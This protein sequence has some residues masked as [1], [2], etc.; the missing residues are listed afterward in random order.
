M[1]DKMSGSSLPKASLLSAFA[2][3]IVL[4]LVHQ[5]LFFGHGLGVSMPIFVIVFYVYMYS[6]NRDRCQPLSWIGRLL[7]VVIMMLALTYVLFDNPI[8]YVLNALAIAA[9][10]SV[11]MVLLFGEKSHGWSE[12]GIIGQALS[13]W[14]YQNFRHIVTPFR[15][16]KTAAFRN[17]KDER[18]RVLGKVII[19]LLIALPLL[20]IIISLLASADGMFEKLLSG[21]PAWIGT[22]TFGSGLPRLIWTCFFTF[23]FFCY[24]WGFVQPAPRNTEREA[25]P[26][27]AVPYHEPV[28]IKF[29]PVITATVLIVMNLVYVVFVVLQFGYLFGAW[30]G[31]LPEGT[32]YAEYAR[33]GFG[34]LVMVTGINFVLM[35]SVLKWTE[36][37]S[38]IVQTLNS[39][40]LYI[41]VG[42]SGVMLYSGYTRLVMYEEAYGYTYIRYL[43]HAFMIFLGLLLLVAAVRIHVRQLP[44]A[45]YYIVL[46][47]IAYVVVN[48]VGIDVRIAENNLERYR[49]TS[50]IDKEYLSELS[51]DAIPLLIDFSRKEHG[52]LDEFLQ[53]RLM[54]MTREESNW[55]EFNWAKYRAQQE[56]HDYILE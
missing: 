18:K 6:F 14:F 41:L 7:F 37:G 43:V 16:F 17:V 53:T 20:L 39:G 47:L 8:F 54:S 52:A 51:A 19:G 28:A 32:S 40:L 25:Q 35:I 26:A 30:E 1:H 11:H 56:L 13:H 50:V 44:L 24:L 49:T 55:P 15:M 45:K 10:I 22:L 21:I 2:G 9:L 5:Y 42:C 46:A 48:Y 34:E 4:A 36:F 33:R 29:D 3:A 23:C 12:I 27:V 38:G 31:A